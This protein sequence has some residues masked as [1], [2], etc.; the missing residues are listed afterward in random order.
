MS[1]GDTNA[2]GGRIDHLGYV[3]EMWMGLLLTAL[4]LLQQPPQFANLNDPL[5]RALAVVLAAGA[6]LC[7]FGA[8]LGTKLLLPNTRRR[9]SYWFEMAGLPLIIVTLAWYSYSAIDSSEIVVSAL[10]GGLG[11][12]MEVGS[13]RFMINMVAEMTDREKYKGDGYLN[14]DGGGGS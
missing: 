9:V 12:A 8:V 3:P 7:L 13:L 5:E 4:Y 10:G 11:L 6:T 14:D 2:E 1:A